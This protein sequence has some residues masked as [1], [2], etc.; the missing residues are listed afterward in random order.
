MPNI[1]IAGRAPPRGTPH[2][3]KDI[4]RWLSEAEMP[5]PARHAQVPSDTTGYNLGYLRHPGSLNGLDGKN[6]STLSACHSIS[7]L[8]PQPFQRGSRCVAQLRRGTLADQRIER[9]HGDGSRIA[10]P[11]EVL[12]NR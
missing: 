4:S 7:P 2:V 12:H 9:L 5:H 8:D 3:F 6:A 1:T 10:R 11:P